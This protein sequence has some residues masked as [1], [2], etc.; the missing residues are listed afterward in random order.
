MVRAVVLT[1]VPPASLVDLAADDLPD[2]DVTIDVRWSSL[3]YKDGLAVTGSGRIARKLPMTCGADLAGT[4]AA[5][6]NPAVRVGDEVLVTGW[7]LSETRPGGYTQRQRVPASMVTARPEGLSLRQTMAIGTAGLTSMLCVMAL[8]G[9]GLRPGAGPVLVTGASGGVGT[10]AVAVLASLG[11]EVTAST[12]SPAAHPLLRELGATEI[13]DRAELATPGRP[14]GKERWVGAID[15]VGSQTLASV[16]ASIRYGGAV[17]ACGLAGGNDLPATVLPF[18]LRGVSLLGIDSVMC[19]PDLRD[20]AWSRLAS[21][22]PVSLLDRVTQ[23][24]PLSD[25]VKLGKQILAGEI[26]GRVVVDVR[27]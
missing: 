22:L 9:A 24:E 7:G 19:P 15:T 4:V 1:D 18:I 6:E 3:N 14:L 2:G 12:G 20:A 13:I 27:A 10:L 5:S 17:A 8:E 11:Y 21:D 26:S 16:L 25:I 23:V